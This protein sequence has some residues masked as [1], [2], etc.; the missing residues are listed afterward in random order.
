MGEGARYAYGDDQDAGHLHEDGDAIGHVVGVV[1]RGKPSEV[2]PRPPNGEKHERVADQDGP[3]FSSDEATL[4]SRTRLGHRYYE[5][6][7]EEQFQRARSSTT[8]R[9]VPG[10][11]RHIKRHPVIIA[12]NATGVGLSRRRR[13]GSGPWHQLP[14]LCEKPSTD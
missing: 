1:R 6:Q 10:R 8:L 3:R 7:V 2:H 11:H 4:K 14:A 5:R 9:R 12:D 13:V